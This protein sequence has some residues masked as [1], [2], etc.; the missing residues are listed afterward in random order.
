MI[1]SFLNTGDIYEL[2]RGGQGIILANDEF[3]EY[4]IKKSNVSGRCG[5]WNLEYR[6]LN[7]INSKYVP[8]CSQVELI[9]V[10]EFLIDED[11]CYMM[12]DRIYRPDNME[13]PAIQTYFGSE[14]VKLLNKTRGLYLGL[15][16]LSEYLSNTQ[17]INTIR[18]LGQTI[19]NFH[20]G[21]QYDLTDVEYLLGHKYN[22]PINRIYM[23][24][25]DLV[26]PIEKYDKFS[27]DTLHWSLDSESYFPKPD[28]L[29]YDVFESAYLEEADRLGYLDFAETIIEQYNE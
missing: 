19:S 11:T 13:G 28:T 16:Q 3:P 7:D 4:V 26:R 6:T 14:D 5:S 12:L 24:D 9:N 22:E 1:K 21:L 25:F 20:Y 8:L 27:A 18:C 17:I 15:K 23:L 2:G 10:Y 29:Y